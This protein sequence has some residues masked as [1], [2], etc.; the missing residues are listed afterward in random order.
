[1]WPSLVVRFVGLVT[2]LVL[3]LACMIL[4]RLRTNII[5]KR[6]KFR[7]SKKWTLRRSR[8]S[9]VSSGPHLDL[10]SFGPGGE[11]NV[12]PADAAVEITTLWQNYLRATGW[13]EMAGWILVSTLIVFLLA[14]VPFAVLGLPSFPGIAA[15]SSRRCT[16]FSGSSMDWSSGW[17]FSGLA[18]RRT[19]A[20]G[21][22]RS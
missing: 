14:I 9:A 11:A 16:S 7:R 4:I 2:T 19:P 22:S 17:S 12:K 10:T 15:S 1:M 13:R 8:W 21:S 6:F 20:R 3:T 5:S 18:T